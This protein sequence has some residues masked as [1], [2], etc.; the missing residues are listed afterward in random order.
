[1]IVAGETRA[2]INAGSSTSLVKRRGTLR[3][4]MGFVVPSIGYLYV[5]CLRV[6][7]HVQICGC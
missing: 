3:A 4:L 2:E 6:L 7:E 1:M 5:G